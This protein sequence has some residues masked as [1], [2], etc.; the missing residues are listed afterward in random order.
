LVWEYRSRATLFGL[1]LVH[2]R[3]GKPPGQAAQPAMGWFAFGEIAYGVLF[4][5]GAVA[6]GGISIGGASVGIISFGG[7]GFGLIAFGGIAFGGVAL[8]GAAIGLIASGGIALGWHAALGGVAA[9]HELAL[10]GAALANHVNDPVAREFFARHRWL[11]FTQAGPRNLFWT[12]C[13]APVFLQTLAWNWWR[14]KMLKRAS[15]K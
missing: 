14:R 15:Q 4:A 1:P 13:F 3:G 10:G 8:G 6:V 9:A 2:C 11:D 5:S 7:F 12:L